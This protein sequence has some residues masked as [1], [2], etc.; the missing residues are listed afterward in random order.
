MARLAC[1]R[2]ESGCMQLGGEYMELARGH[3]DLQSGVQHAPQSALSTDMVRWGSP[4]KT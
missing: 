1:G 4:G 2:V 3:E